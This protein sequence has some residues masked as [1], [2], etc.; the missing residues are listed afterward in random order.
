MPLRCLDV[1]LCTADFVGPVRNGG[2]G[3]AYHALARTLA[4]AGH[5]VTV[6]FALGDFCEQ[7]V[8][9]DWIAYYRAAG[10]EFI[11]LPP[12]DPPVQAD[13]FIKTSFECYQWLAAQEAAGKVFDVIHFHEWR[14]L[15]FYS[16]LA[17][18]Q[19]LNFARSVLCVGTHSPHLWHLEGMRCQPRAIQDLQADFLER[20]SVEWA[21]C[22][23]SPSRYM[24]DWIKSQD[25]KLP[26]STEIIQY[27]LTQHRTPE[28]LTSAPARTV[29]QIVFFGRLETRKG[30]ALF[31]DAIDL[32]PRDGSLPPFE[33]VF[34]GKKGEIGGIPAAD[35]IALRAKRWACSWNIVDHLD[36]AG[37]MTLLS[38]PNRFAVMPSLVENLPL[39]VLECLGMGIPFLCSDLPG[40]RE[41]VSAGDSERVTFALRPRDL[42]RKLIDALTNGLKPAQPA[43]RPAQTKAAWLAWHQQIA[44]KFP[45]PVHS[46][47]RPLVSICI[48]HFNRPKK[49]AQAIESIRRQDYPNFEVILVDDG[50]DQPDALRYIA[51]LNDEFTS[52][53]WTII[54]QPNRYLGA[55]RNRAAKSAKG[56]WLLFMDDD[57]YAMPSEVSTFVQCALT[58]NSDCLTCVPTLF[59]SDAPPGPHAPGTLLPPLG[60]AVLLGLF[61]NYF[62][63]A[64]CLVRRGVFEQLGGYTEDYGV[65][66]EDCELYAKAILAGFKVMCV[67]HSLYWYRVDPGSMVRTTENYANQTRVL[68]PYM[69]SLPKPLRHL[70]LLTQGLYLDRFAPRQPAAAID[71][72]AERAEAQNLVDTYWDSLSWRLTN[73][74]RRLLAQLLGR[75]APRRPKV[76]TLADAFSVIED[77][78]HCASWEMTGPLRAVGRIFSSTNKHK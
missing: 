31:C 9:A 75:R 22:V 49:L 63:D 7:G 50:S 73:F 12:S 11:P 20:G 57:N 4:S 34:L 39:T 56:E 72:G 38:E 46:S 43:I 26:A 10:I 58:S 15:G 21:D 42:S 64:N 2:I 62:G 27:I 59:E 61:S 3:T 29:N 17:K 66:Y 74:P 32:F 55:A 44:G 37:A 65:G 53:G 30:L 13:A 24:L 6:L 25:W 77:M 76:Q 68:R 36:H 28:E 51:S 33:I 8:I 23:V 69:A 60:G 78:R 67:P 18:R 54:R 41:L 71:A 47:E 16:T 19:G 5:P 45:G 40:N 52:R 14:G 1:C 70:P 48:C 35:Y